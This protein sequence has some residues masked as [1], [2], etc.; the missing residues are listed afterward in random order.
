MEDFNNTIVTEFIL[1]AFSNTPDLQMF[2]FTVI[3]LMYIIC[4]IGNIVTIIL[5]RI[6]PSLHNPMYF[7]ITTFAF[8][9]IMFVSVTI[10]KL[11]DNL[12]TANKNIHFIGCF[13]QLYLFNALGESE[14]ILLSMMVF[15]RYIA[16][17]SPLQYPAI[18]T[19]S[20]CIVLA[21][22]PWTVG[23]VMSFIVTIF[24]A[25]LEFCGPNEVNHFFCDL[26]PLQN[27]SCSNS[28]ISKVV[29]SIVAVITLVIPFSLIIRY[30]IHIILIV[31]KIKTSDGKKKAFSTCSSHL[32]VA[33]LFFGTAFTVYVRP[34]GSHYDKYLALI[35]TV[36]IP[37]LNPFIYT[38]R[39]RDIKTVF[40]QLVSQLLKQL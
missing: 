32:I 33:S 5:V 28:F 11:L 36:V 40:L 26:A 8:L 6:A 7:F 9:E 31:S 10:P 38:L 4:I 17:H 27:L 39:N 25:Q 21:L 23:F 22:T 1:L 16:I 30:Y 24:T 34:E 2:L 37:M 20:F 12:I 29:T 15:D 35:Y 13:I 3:L 14:C 19:H 18:M